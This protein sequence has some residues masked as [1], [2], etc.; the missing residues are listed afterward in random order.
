MNAPLTTDLVSRLRLAESEHCRL[1]SLESSLLGEAADE[2]GR[3]HTIIR[4][5]TRVISQ[6]EP[7]KWKVERIVAALDGVTS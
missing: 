1:H 3:L 5:V 4:S 2:I 6:N 7:Y